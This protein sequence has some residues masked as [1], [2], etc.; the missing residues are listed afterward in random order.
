MR[1]ENYLGKILE[2]QDLEEGGKELKDL[3]KRRQDIEKKLKAHFSDSSPSIRWAGSMAKGT[4][5]R[6]SYDGDMTCYFA[7]EENGAGNTLAEI[8][9]NTVEALQNEY[10]VETK[11][12]AIRVRDFNEWSIDFHID[13]VPGRYTSDDKEEVFLHRTNGEKERL[14]TNLQTHIDHIKGSGVIDAIRLIKLCKV[15]NSLDAAKTFVLELLVVKLLKNKK[16]SS[17][18]SQLEHVL[19][20]F[21]DKADSLAVEDPANPKGNDLKPILDGCRGQ[22]STVASDTLWQIENKGWLAVFGPTDDVGNG[23]SKKEALR[24][25]ASS[26]QS[27]TKPWARG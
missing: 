9:Q 4:M 15:R 3:R 12:S 13:V 19:T 5:V 10:Q 14:K 22:I 6:E 23:G 21:R 1:A 16:S 20:E 11:A 26:I 27:P 2:A 25:V 8:Y 17:L 18:E 7:H 24:A